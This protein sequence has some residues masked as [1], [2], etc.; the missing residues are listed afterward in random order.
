MRRPL[1]GRIGANASK[2][3]GHTSAPVQLGIEL[4]AVAVQFEQWLGH[5]TTIAADVVRYEHAR[6]VKKVYSDRGRVATLHGAADRALASGVSRDPSMRIVR[7]Q[8][9]PST[10]RGLRSDTVRDKVPA[11][12]EASCV[13]SI[14]LRVNSAQRLNVPRPRVNDANELIATLRDH[15]ETLHRVRAEERLSRTAV[16]SVFAD[17]AAVTVWEG[18]LL[19]TTD[20]WALGYLP[21]RRFNAKRCMALAPD[22]GVDVDELKVEQRIA[23]S[24]RYTVL[25]LDVS[26]DDESGDEYAE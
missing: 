4:A 3:Q 20:G 5:P 12:W 19:I 14:S 13:D 23:G 1:G 17:V 18:E 8:H 10:V 15:I 24:V 6:A 25:G 9:P 11:L 16:S 21:Q 22:F 7:T 26:D 2:R